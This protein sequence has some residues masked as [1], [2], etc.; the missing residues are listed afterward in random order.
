LQQTGVTNCLNSLGLDFESYGTVRMM[1]RS[2]NEARGIVGTVDSPLG[3]K[4]GPL[5]LECLPSRIATEFDAVGLSLRAVDHSAVSADICILGQAWHLVHALWPELASSIEHLVRCVHLLKSPSPEVDCSYS[6]PALPFSVFLSVPDHGAHARIER[7][8][9]ALV[10]E[11]MHLQ[12]SLIERRIPLIE[13][14]RTNAFAFSPWRN[15]ERKVQ[16]VLHALYVFVVVK[17]LWQRAVQ[18]APF[19]LDLGFAEARV[20]TIRDEVARAHHL[21]VSPGL[22]VEGHQLV[23]QLLALG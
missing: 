22:S 15:C 20:H 1:M 23:R 21:A 16:G 17:E 8:T 6:R 3:A 11:T 10:H 5:L 19:G 2:T 12:L 7:A 18:R 14:G 9:E 4:G 13:S